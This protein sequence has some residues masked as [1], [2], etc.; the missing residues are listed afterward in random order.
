[1]FVYLGRMSVRLCWAYTDHTARA[2]SNIKD[3]KD[4]AREAASSGPLAK[5]SVL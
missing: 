3:L 4:L 2:L 1:M 5:H